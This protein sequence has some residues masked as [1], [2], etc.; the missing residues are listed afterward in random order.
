VFLHKE[1]L[2]LGG[3]GISLYK[4]FQATPSPEEPIVYLLRDEFTTPQAAPI[5]SPRTCEP[6]PGTITISSGVSISGGQAAVPAANGLTT[7]LTAYQPGIVF[8]HQSRVLGMSN[9]D[10]AFGWLKAASFATRPPSNTY[11]FF[12]TS[13]YAISIAFGGSGLGA[14]GYATGGNNV[15]W[16]HVLADPYYFLVADSK[17]IYVLRNPFAFTS[18]YG[19]ECTRINGRSV[20]R[21][22]VTVLGSPWN[23][24][25]GVATDFL[26]TALAGD[27]ITA[28]AD[29]FIQAIWT[30]VAGETWELMIRR[31][32]DDNCWIIRC[33]QAGSTIKL[34]QKEGGVETERASA[35]QT[36]ANGSTYRLVVIADTQA[37]F[38]FVG[39]E[40]KNTYAS[41]SFNQTATGVKTS[42]AVNNLIAWPRVLSGAALAALEAV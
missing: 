33:S 32:D 27:T 26:L 39:E 28:A 35:A 37:I 9:E 11:G 25:H 13:N 1:L 31:T 2:K 18:A 30:A 8:K 10:Y 17:L 22:L 40:R 7:P 36:W 12:V 34:I 4:L 5:S 42:H 15:T 24:S 3:L 20:E 41:A 21:V 6:G 29:A 14:T 38:N 16:C 19:I 23:T